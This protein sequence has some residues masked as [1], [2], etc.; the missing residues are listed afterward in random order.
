MGGNAVDRPA[1]TLEGPVRYYLIVVDVSDDVVDRYDFPSDDARLEFVLNQEA[2]YGGTW[3]KP[4]L[5]TVLKLDVPEPADACQS[6]DVVFFTEEELA[7]A[8]VRCQACGD[9]ALARTAHRH[10]KGWVGDNCCWDG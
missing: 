7:T 3:A 6:P 2:E 1:N 5:R 4:G 10:G 8:T 9:L